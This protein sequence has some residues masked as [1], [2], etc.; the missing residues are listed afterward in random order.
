MASTAARRNSFATGVH[1]D[2]SKPI[3]RGRRHH[4]ARCLRSLR[5]RSRAARVGQSICG[6]DS[7]RSTLGPSRCRRIKTSSNHPALRACRLESEGRV[8]GRNRT[9][10]GLTWSSPKRST[11]SGLA[12]VEKTKS[13]IFL[14]IGAPGGIRTHDPWLRRPILYPAELRARHMKSYP[15]EAALGLY[16]HYFQSRHL[17]PY[18]APPS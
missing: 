9:A 18:T 11:D 4:G 15:I 5:H 8:V 12:R 6:A 2:A 13:R 3:A 1:A 7:F 17:S 16:R 14:E 10:G